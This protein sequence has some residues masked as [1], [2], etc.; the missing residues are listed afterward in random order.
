M[1]PTHS[2]YVPAQQCRQTS[3]TAV[4]SNMIFMLPSP[5]LPTVQCFTLGA[6]SQQSRNLINYNYIIYRMGTT[7]RI[8][9]T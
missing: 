2:Q 4:M 7:G 5:A 9:L 1:H 6:L 8:D 3:D